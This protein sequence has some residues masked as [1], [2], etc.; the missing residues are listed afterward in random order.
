MTDFIEE[1]NAYYRELFRRYGA[2]SRSVGYNDDGTHSI[3]TRRVVEILRYHNA[4]SVFEVGVGLGH[5]GLAL[6]ELAPEIAYSGCDLFSSFIDQTKQSFPDGRFICGDILDVDPPPSD[7]VVSI[8]AFNSSFGLPAVRW[9]R[10]TRARLKRM[11]KL[12]SNGMIINFLSSSAQ[13]NKRQL[14]LIYHDAGEL[15]R[16]STANLSRFVNVSASTPLFEF[17]LAV[18]KPEA[19]RSRFSDANI[20]KYFNEPSRGQP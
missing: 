6:R 15:L 11:Y 14:S 3:R 19:I 2:S 20:A 13:K 16:W 9:R 7:F 4:R 18:F 5:L 10:E 17:E 8:G 1:N 12:S